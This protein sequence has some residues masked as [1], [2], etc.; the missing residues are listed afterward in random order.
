MQ[1]PVAGMTFINKFA[2]SATLPATPM[3][4]T[5]QTFTV[6][7]F[8]MI[9]YSFFCFFATVCYSFDTYQCDVSF[10]IVIF[11]LEPLISVIS[12]QPDIH[13]LCI[14]FQYWNFVDFLQV[15]FDLNLGHSV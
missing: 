10:F 14:H 1:S 12:H 15:A 8:K 5:H 3:R 2:L 9:V 11:R 13:N 7:D 6:S 4:H